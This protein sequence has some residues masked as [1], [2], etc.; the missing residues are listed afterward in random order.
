M[1]AVPREQSGCRGGSRRTVQSEVPGRVSSTVSSEAHGC[2]RARTLS[3][4]D[5]GSRTT[6][7]QR[8]R[9]RKRAWTSLSADR[10]VSAHLP[11]AAPGSSHLPGPRG[12]RLES[13]DMDSVVFEDVA[14]DFSQEEWALLDAAQRELY[15]EVM[16]ET[17]RNLA[18]VGRSPKSRCWQDQ[19]PLKVPGKHL[20]QLFP[21]AGH[22]LA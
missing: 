9:G 6:S 15:R 5:A 2:G 12:G 22:S 7:N 8:S 21:A 16:L 18:S 11:R 1:R 3:T 10:G 17:F 4:Q 20:F 19:L 14:L 13:P